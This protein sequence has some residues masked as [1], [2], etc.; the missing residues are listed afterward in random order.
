MRLIT[1]GENI[2]SIYQFMFEMVFESFYSDP[3]AMLMKESWILMHIT[4]F[5]I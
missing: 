1:E 2:I 4:D 3:D 5:Q